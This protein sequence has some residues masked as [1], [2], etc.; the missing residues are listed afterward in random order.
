M[1][2]VWGFAMATIGLFML[3]A[4]TFRSE[5]IVYR[6]MVAR[7]R[8]LWGEGDLVHRFYQGS[9]VIITV[10]GLCWALGIIWDH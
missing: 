10:L 9:G 1:N 8:M 6:L 4:G 5:F 3:V 2:F 7:S